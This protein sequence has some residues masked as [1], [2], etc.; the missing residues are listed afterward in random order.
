M[1]LG[2]SLRLKTKFTTCL[3]PIK[4]YLAGTQSCYHDFP[5]DKAKLARQH[6][7][8]KK[9]K[10]DA[11]LKYQPYREITPLNDIV[12]L[13][14]S[15]AKPN[16]EDSQLSSNLESSSANESKT[17]LTASVQSDGIV[18]SDLS[19]YTGEEKKCIICKYKIP[20]DYKN[21]RLLSQ[22]VSP[23]SGRIYGSSV[24]GLCIPM[25]SRIAKLIKRSRTMGLMPIT[26]KEEQFQ[27]DPDLF[28]PFVRRF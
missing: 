20:L 28:N 23:F 13:I 27:K 3:T 5:R 24:T 6:A 26:R 11:H 21:V 15:Q 9:E 10:E 12:Q 17:S 4:Y 8:K 14:R 7:A 1:V 19:P 25:Q 16:H 22:F 18:C 2:I